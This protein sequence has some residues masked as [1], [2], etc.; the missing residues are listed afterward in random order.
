MQ[1][2]QK[3]ITWRLL[4]CKDCHNLFQRYWWVKSVYIFWATL[5]IQC[6]L[7]LRLLQSYLLCISRIRCIRLISFTL[8]KLFF[9]SLWFCNYCSLRCLHWSNNFEEYWSVR[10]LLHFRACNDL[11]LPMA[12][13]FISCVILTQAPYIYKMQVSP[14]QQKFER[15]KASQQF[16]FHIVYTQFYST[17][18]SG[19]YRREISILIQGEHKVF[20]WLQTF[21]ARKLR[22]IQ[23]YIFFYH[24]LNYFLKFYVMCLLLCYSCITC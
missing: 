11:N 18:D 24:Y 16:N 8:L 4:A 20:P 22:G 12:K 21:I 13:I 1:Q 3:F 9:L 17:A 6:S 14:S 10:T 15:C 2:F 7:F 5:Y 23:I 19:Q